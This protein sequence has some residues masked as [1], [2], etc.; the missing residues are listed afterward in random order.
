V[1]G[2][3]C[4][5]LVSKLGKRGIGNEAFQHSSSANGTGSHGGQKGSL[6]T[7]REVAVEQ[8]KVL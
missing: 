3:K 5:L 7:Y 6:F 4:G 1:S 2:K 8:C